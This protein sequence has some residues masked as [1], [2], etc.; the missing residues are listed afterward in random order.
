M[1]MTYQN[2]KRVLEVVV[3]TQKTKAK[4]DKCVGKIMCK[5]K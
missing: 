1:F 2:M 5:P 4:A 3:T